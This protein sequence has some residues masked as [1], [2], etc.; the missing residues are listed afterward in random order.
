MQHG[1]RPDAGHR[2]IENIGQSVGRRVD[3]DPRQPAESLKHRLLQQCRVRGGL[4]WIGQ[5]LHR[6]EQ[7]RNQ[8]RCLG[9][10][11]QLALLLAAENPGKQPNLPPLDQCA[12]P[13]RAVNLVCAEGDYI[14]PQLLHFKRQLAERLHTVAVQQ[15][16]RAGRFQKPCRLPHRVD[17]AGFIV[18]Q[19]HAEEDGIPIHCGRDFLGRDPAVGRRGQTNHLE[20][21]TF[22][23]RCRLQHRGVLDR[24]QNHPFAAAAQSGRSAKQGEVVRL[25]PAGGKIDLLRPGTNPRGDGTPGLLQHGLGGDP[26]VIQGGWISPNASQH[27]LHARNRRRAGLCCRTVVKITAACQTAPLPKKGRPRL[28]I[29]VLYYIPPP[30]TII[31]L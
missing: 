2:K 7:P 14:R 16:R 27:L 25:R 17:G 22:Q 13:L 29:L 12:D 1:L 6:A 24:R 18:H 5:C 30:F 11:A 4:L 19:H 3:L 26:H 20:P 10:R 28:I 9:S 15:R 23:L 21:L 8:R 31:K